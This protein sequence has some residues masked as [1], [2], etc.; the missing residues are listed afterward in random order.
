MLYESSGQASYETFERWLGARLT[1]V[2]DDSLLSQLRLSRRNLGEKVQMAI[3]PFND[4]V[5][6]K[7]MQELQQRKYRQ[8]HR[9]ATDKQGNPAYALT[10]E[11]K[12]SCLDHQATQAKV[13][14]NMQSLRM[15][16]EYADPFTFSVGTEEFPPKYIVNITHPS[17]GHSRR[18]DSVSLVDQMPNPEVWFKQKIDE[19]KVELG[20]SQFGKT[21]ET[22][23]SKIE[24]KNKQG[25][26]VTDKRSKTP[27]VPPHCPEHGNELVRGPEPGTLVCTVTGCKKVARKKVRPTAVTAE[28]VTP[29]EMTELTK[30]E[31]LKLQEERAAD[32]SGVFA[33]LEK[34]QKQFEDIQSETN[35]Q[36]SS[37]V[38]S[39]I[40]KIV[41]AM[42]PSRYTPNDNMPKLVSAG[43]RFYLAQDVGQ[44]REAY[45]DVTNVMTTRQR[46][47]STKADSSNSGAYYYINVPP[48]TLTTGEELVVLKLGI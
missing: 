33:D 42:N 35:V 38:A 21:R 40:Q 28:K 43:G 17:W 10:D 46:I 2:A 41:A 18:S 14:T 7:R 12:I 31:A 44:G 5:V 6:V 19:M 13:R 4:P 15:L 1:L 23:Q 37:T 27:A 22:L 8:G 34:M 24:Q 3:D 25:Y 9:N 16:E 30:T 39:T 45:V 47:D 32:R 20:Y 26:S 48:I 36:A 29:P 11:D